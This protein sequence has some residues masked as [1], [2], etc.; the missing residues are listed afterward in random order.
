MKFNL[1]NVTEIDIAHQAS[2]HISSIPFHQF[3][4]IFLRW[5]GVSR[6]KSLARSLSR[7]VSHKESLARSLLGGVSRKESLARSLSRGDSREETLARSLSRGVSCE[8]SLVRNSLS[9]SSPASVLYSF[10]LTQKTTLLLFSLPPYCKSRGLRS[11]LIVASLIIRCLSSSLFVV[12]GCAVLRHAI[13]SSFSRLLYE[14]RTEVQVDC[15]VVMI[16][17][18]LLPLWFVIVASWFVVCV[19]VGCAVVRH[20]VPSRI[21]TSFSRLP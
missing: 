7:G 17:C 11:K 2:P 9:R 1:T 15:C 14:Q 20:A 19:V 4:R 12:V 8:E 13:S 16:V 18:C 21:S 10:S 3:K 5:R 6:E